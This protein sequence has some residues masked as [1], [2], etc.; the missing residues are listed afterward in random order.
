MDRTKRNVAA[1]GALTIVAVAVFF[2]GLYYLLGSTFVRN[3]MDIVVQL[4]NGGGLK[5]GDRVLYQGVIVGSVNDVELEPGKGVLAHLRLND[6]LPLPTD[7]RATV[8]GDVFGAHSIELL[9]GTAARMVEPNDTVRGDLTPAL[10]DEASG[11]TAKANTILDRANMLLSQEVISDMHAATRGLRATS[12]VLPAGAAQLRAAL[13]EVQAASASLKRVSQEIEDAHTGAALNRAIARIDSGANRIGVAAA[14]LNT[15]ILS[16]QSVF[17]KIDN[18][19]GS[20][21]KLIN[22]PA[23][24]A[25]LD[26]AAKN[27]NA[28]ILDIKANPKRYVTIDLF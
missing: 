4:S 24:Y 3:G 25:D 12:Q 13:I 9:P 23:L 26:S 2:F 27:L 1:L 14:N 11:L 7:T 15:S 21:G 5:R 28:L 20:L 22:D 8:S 10:M 17:A 19:H 16:L 6:K 18:G